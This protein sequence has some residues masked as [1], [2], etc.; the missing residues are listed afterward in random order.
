[1]LE[2]VGLPGLAVT[3]H[4][5][6]T[7]GRA[8]VLSL[9]ADTLGVVPRAA[10]ADVIT[11]R[12]GGRR[13]GHALCA[14]NLGGFSVEGAALVGPSSVRAEAAWP[15]LYFECRRGRLVGAWTDR[16]PFGR[17]VD[18]LLPDVAQDLVAPALRRLVAVWGAAAGAAGWLRSWW[19]HD[20]A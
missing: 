4:R 10:G 1:M 20:L 18:G 3:C 14:T 13:A 12:Q 16:P 7:P 5:V 17:S 19:R 15:R 2:A 8:A 11:V 9:M 6:A